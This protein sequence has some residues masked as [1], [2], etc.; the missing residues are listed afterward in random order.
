MNFDDNKKQKKSKKDKDTGISSMKFMKQGEANKK[1]KLKNQ[2]KML[3]D[4]IKEGKSDE[5]SDNATGGGLFGS[6]NKFKGGIADKF[7]AD[8][9]KSMIDTEDILK[10]AKEMFAHQKQNPV[11]APSD[12]DSQEGSGDA[13]S[14]S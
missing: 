14:S 8:P 10:T 4:Q 11:E 6:S 9:K 7:G 2:A 13:E 12:D 3:I 1:E 5:E